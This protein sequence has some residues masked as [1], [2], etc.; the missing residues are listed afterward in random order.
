VTLK[1]R[2]VGFLQYAQGD[3]V[4]TYL[5]RW[6]AQSMRIN[7]T[8]FDPTSGHNHNGSGTNGP[9]VA[10]G[11]GVTMVW[12]GTWSSATGYSKS[13]GVSYNGSSYIA[14]NAVGPSAT[15]PP[16]DPTNWGLLAQAGSPGAV[17]P[18]GPQ[19]PP[20]TTGATGAT[21]A[22]GP[23]G[24]QG[25][26]GIGWVTA[27]RAPTSADTGY[28]TG[29]LWLN[30]TTGQYWLLTS[31]APVTWTLQANLTGPQGATGPQGNPG[32]TGATGP[33]GPTG[34]TGPQGPAGTNTWGSP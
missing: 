5:Q 1:T 17:G 30:T 2:V 11:G 31:N 4:Q 10:G 7:D 21:G 32:A 20:G 25:A 6:L 24:P 23:T 8:L 19:G 3:D 18:A 27:T 14:L 28:A 34:A 12:R 13:D 16:S 29:T 26:Q 15:P 22:T 9:I 33:A